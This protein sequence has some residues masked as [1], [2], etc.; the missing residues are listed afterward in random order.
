[1]GQRKNWKLSGTAS[2]SL[3]MIARYGALFCVGILFARVL[4]TDALAVWEH[5]LL[6]ITTLSAFWVSSLASHVMVSKG[7]EGSARRIGW[8]L[9]LGASAIAVVVLWNKPWQELL[10]VLAA[11]TAAPT[12]LHE[13]ELYKA[14]R[15]QRVGL[16]AIGWAILLMICCWLAM[17]AGTTLTN[18]AMGV[19]TY[20]ALRILLTTPIWRYN[21]FKKFDI[22]ADRMELAGLMPLILTALVGVGMSTLDG[23]FAQ[24]LLD[25]GDFVLFRYGARELPITFLIANAISAEISKRVADGAGEGLTAA[26]ALGRGFMGW[27]IPLTM[28]LI[29]ASPWLF[30]VVYG[31]KF[32]DAASVF[33]IYLLLVV[34]RSVFPQSILLGLGHR[35]T[36]LHG[37]L[38]EFGLNLMLNIILFQIMGMLGLAVSTVI[39]F[40]IGKLYLMRAAGRAGAGWREYTAAG[41]WILGSIALA[42][43]ICISMFYQQF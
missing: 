2:L 13:F 32:S 16:N 9:G 18:A 21:G 17:A 3:L 20:Y 30:S 43:T 7:G 28:V 27:A 15:Y 26:K 6:V 4:P 39:S 40:T 37:S 33:N 35:K 23:W 41:W 10:M 25:E 19:G 29:I 1:M 42:V 24:G 12:L 8:I 31:E 38:I 11:L 5:G 22:R 14:G 34:Q 36:L